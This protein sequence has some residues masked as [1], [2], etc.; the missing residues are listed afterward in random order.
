[1][2][3]TPHPPALPGRRR[4][5]RARRSPTPTPPAAALW[6]QHQ[7][8][9]PGCLRGTEEQGA[10]RRART[11]LNLRSC[12]P[13]TLELEAESAPSPSGDYQRVFWKVDV[14]PGID[15]GLETSKV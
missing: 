9:S 14:R 6:P 10:L 8:C 7:I 11:E 13:S 4:L 1:M 5:P 2:G 15:A 3:A 12:P